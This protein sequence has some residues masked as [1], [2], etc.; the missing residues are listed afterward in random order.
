MA[1]ELLAFEVILFGYLLGSIPPSYIIGKIFFKVDIRKEGSGNAGGA[2]S[3]RLFGQ[4]VGLLVGFFDL[5]KGTFAVL[6]AKEFYTNS[7]AETGFF[8][9]SNNIIALAGFAAVVGHCF[10]LFLKFSGGKGGATTMG[11]VLGIDPVSF[12]ILMIFWIIIVGTT[13]FTSLGNLLGFGVIPLLFA[14]RTDDA[15]FEYAGIAIIVLIYYKHRD[16]IGRLFRG[17][18]RKFGQKETISKT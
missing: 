16:N 3:A 17:E 5:I 14:F 7:G 15:V 9:N 8:A 13:R 12:V 4:K 1:G 2:N 10:S 18:E 6:I 11:M